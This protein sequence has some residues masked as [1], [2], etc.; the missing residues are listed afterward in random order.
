MARVADIA[1]REEEDHLLGEVRGVI[2]RPLDPLGHTL[3]VA[4]L[5]DAGRIFL[6]ELEDVLEDL[7][8]ERVDLVVLREDRPGLLLIRADE[9]VAGVAAQVPGAGSPLG[10]VGG[11]PWERWSRSPAAT[12]ALAARQG[13]PGQPV[14]EATTLSTVRSTAASGTTM[15]WFFAPPRQRERFPVEAARP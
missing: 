5:L 7:R 4:A 11:G 10:A 9:G 13:W 3:D 1:P 14:K 2:A 8:V 12:S 15:R 6:H